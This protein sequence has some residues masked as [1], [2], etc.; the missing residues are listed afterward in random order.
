MKFRSVL[1][2]F[3]VFSVLA[4][5][6]Y[7]SYEKRWQ[8]IDK[9]T[10]SADSLKT[11]IIEKFPNSLLSFQFCQDEFYD[12]LYPIWNNDSLKVVVITK[13]LRKYPQ[14]QWA[15]TM[16]RYLAHSLFNLKKYEQ[17]QQTLS[18]FRENFADDYKPWQLSAKYYVEMG[19]PVKAL[20]FA[21]KG[22]RLSKDY[23][24]LSHYP[25]QQWNLE[26]RAASVV[27]AE[28]YA[29]ALKENGNYEKII[30]VLK[31]ELQINKLG[32]ND[33]KT[34][35]GL[36]YWVAAAYFKLGREQ[37]A[38]QHSITAAQLGDRGNIYAKKAEKLLQELTGFSEEELLQFARQKVGY[39]RVVFS[40]INKQ[41]GL[42]NIKAKRVAWSDFNKDDFDDILVNGNRIFK[43]LAGK[44]FIEVTDSIFLEAPNSNG[45]LWADFN[46][47]GWLDIISKD[48][49]QIY[50]QEDGKFQ[51]L[52]NLDNKV[53]TEG[54]AVGDVNNDGWLDVYLAN[55]ESR[56][57]GTIKYLSDQ[58]YVNKNGEKFYEA[59]ERADLYSPE[60]MA[61][62][63]VNMCDFDKDGDLDIYV[64]N[65]RLCENFLWENDGSGHFQNKA[66]KFG[67]AGNETDGWWGHTIGSQWADI[68]SDGDWDLLTCNLAHPRYID[69][70]NK[71]ML[72]ENEN[73]EFRDIRAEAGIKFAETHSE[74]C[75]AD[76]NNDGYLDLYITCVYPQR[77]SFLYLN[78]ADG[79]FSD[80]TYLSGTRYF[81]GWGVAS[82]DFDNDGDV[83]LLVA[84]NKLTLYEN[85]TA[86]D[87]NW[88]E[89]RIYGE[90]H[91]DA[92]GSKIIL[93]HANDSQIRQIQGGKGTTNQNSLK[94]HF[95]FNTV[96]KY[97]KIIFPD[98][99][100]RVLENII[101]NN[102]Y[103]IYQ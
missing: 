92:I 82:S 26:R 74:P 96:P 5:T 77:R 18:E 49:E 59:S 61:G 70:S 32:V 7:D 95:G 14:N 88:I 52:A 28:T 34:A 94:Q 48:P 99:K 58:F 98:G 50:V 81:N 3:L 37:L 21:R 9:E 15:R 97:V 1:F 83:D 93:Q 79:T 51:L 67:L 43:N 17:L 76:F 54:V 4:A 69:F 63:G 56:K 42:Q 101:P 84:G 55:Y 24:V 45:G 6:N 11:E 66:E 85:R 12:K 71:T 86:N 40:N 60:P 53:S 35:A 23:P 72:Y 90:N 68:D 20:E 44:E 22:Y 64:S 91:L 100:Q 33:E 31:T 73:L 2:I 103:N 25:P 27:A 78:N 65:Y 13:L 57:D 47:D 41:V 30:E 8:E 29:E 80:V 39:N 36:H 87:Y 89:F 10:K 46:N 75:W 38:L 62:R 16:Y 102:I 19:K